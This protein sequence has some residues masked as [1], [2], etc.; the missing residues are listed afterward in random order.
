M[1]VL[2]MTEILPEKYLDIDEPTLR[3]RILHI[4]SE[5]GNRLVILGH[6]YQRDEIV[7]LSDFRGDSFKLAKQAA[8]CKEAEFIVFC[9]VH[10]MAEAAAILAA[11][12]QAVLHPDKTAGCPLA[13]YASIEDVERAWNEID[14]VCGVE[15]VTP[16][17]YVNSHAELKAFCG[18]NR[19]IVCTSSN[20]SMVFDWG[21]G[22][23]EK[24][25]FFPDQ[26]LGRNTGKRKGIDKDDM[27]IWDPELELGGNS[28]DAIRQARLIL[29]KGH[30][31]VHTWFRPDH[32]HTIRQRYPQAL[33][34]V[35]PECP[36]EVVDLADAAGST[37]FIIRYVQDAPAGS[38]IAVGTEINLVNRLAHQVQDKT[39]I[40]LARSLCP[41]MYKINLR[42]LC[43]TLENIGQVNFVTVLEHVKTNARVAL[44]RMLRAS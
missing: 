27:I 25:F 41:N 42:N 20:A 44:E 24:M 14:A 37:E 10:F 6:H 21:Y 43:W 3:K 38:V 32:I 11:D 15:N 5:L 7:E 29:W 39:V 16:A 8:E 4:K 12:N 36:E 17:T 18:R 26:H 23:T 31:H 30:C 22:Q 2:D 40:P 35:H 9:G 28:P 13:D 19:G 1:L 33:V 34:V